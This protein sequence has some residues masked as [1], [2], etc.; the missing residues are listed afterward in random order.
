MVGRFARA[1]ILAEVV[2]NVAAAG[3]LEKNHVSS[4]VHK[5]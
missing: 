1:A 3:F 5:V 4:A 2:L